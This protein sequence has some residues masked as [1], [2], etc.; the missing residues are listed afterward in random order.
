[1]KT[2]VLAVAVLA[3]AGCSA[4]ASPKAAALIEADDAGVAGCKLLGT[5][6][7]GTLFG[8]AATGLASHNAMVDA[9]E[10][11]ARLGATHI[12]FTSVDGGG[13]DKTGQ[14]SARAY[15]CR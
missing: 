8:G 6:N 1:M 10:K 15:A 2:Y 13:Y 11:A 9:R 5:V 7:G 4:V 3:L 14:A 12:V